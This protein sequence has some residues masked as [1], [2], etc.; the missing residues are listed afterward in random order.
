MTSITQRNRPTSRVV[1]LCAVLLALAALTAWSL[2][3]AD[4][5]SAQLA[6]LEDVAT[7]GEVGAYPTGFDVS[8][9]T[10][11]KGIMV[12]WKFRNEPSVY[13][14]SGW[15]LDGFRVQR[16]IATGGQRTAQV[17]VK[18][19][20][21]ASARSYMDT[22]TGVH[23]QRWHD[24]TAYTYAVNAIFARTE[25]IVTLTSTS[26]KRHEAHGQQV[27]VKAPTIAT[28]QEV[29]AS[30]TTPTL[31]APTHTDKGYQV[32]WTFDAEAAS[33]PGWKVA[34][35]SLR[36]SNPANPS[37]PKYFHAVL[38]PNRSYVD[39]IGS[40]VQRHWHDGGQFSY[41]IYAIFE[42]KSDGYR[43]AGKDGNTVKS[44]PIATPLEVV[45]Q[46]E[47]PTLLVGAHADGVA[48]G[49]SFDT[50]RI[51]PPGW[52]LAF[53]RGSR[54]EK[55]KDGFTVSGSRVWFD[56]FAKTD[57]SF[58]DP[59]T[60]LSEKKRYPG[61]KYHYALYAVYHRPSDG[62]EQ[63]GKTA[64]VV[65]TT[66]AMPN[67]KNFALY[68]GTGLWTT[69][70]YP[71]VLKWTLPNL[72]WSANTG[73]DKVTEFIITHEGY[74]GSDTTE[75]VRPSGSATS[76]SWTQYGTCYRG[77]KIRAR[78]GLFF[79]KLANYADR[80]VHLC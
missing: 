7:A 77:Y 13:T 74:T 9:S 55:D 42:R 18:T 21:A 29:L 48:M 34:G 79:S 46:Y 67:A 25:T 30:S 50:T 78:Y 39:V 37:L 53:F 2:T 12:K 22:L 43:Q 68:D 15:T 36:R 32:T 58:K 51:T 49:W 80:T 59:L 20:I 23:Q 47:A 8:A 28:Y 31:L 41:T 64:R 66:P 19:G 1:A 76:Y 10:Q 54:H 14:P 35:Y 62:G 44:P 61:N 60:D 40:D 69:G 26:T 52:K 24:G 11:D 33:L 27:T 4:R 3:S 16:W 73:F 38:E 65:F 17:V 75:V 63:V 45:T 70:Q 56:K 5:A 72:S 6:D 71:L 57:R